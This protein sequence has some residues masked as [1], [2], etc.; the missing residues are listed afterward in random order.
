MGNSS[1][2]SP[3]LWKLC[4]SRLEPRVRVFWLSR[5][6]KKRKDSRAVRDKKY[7]CARNAVKRARTRQRDRCKLGSPAPVHFS[8]LFLFSFFG[9]FSFFFP[10]S[11]VAKLPAL[12]HLKFS[13][14]SCVDPRRCCVKKKRKIQKERTRLSLWP[15]RRHS[16]TPP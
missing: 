11:P 3:T 1:H 6:K 10:Q 8:S 7:F 16:A 9:C 12:L 5:T 14:L 2:N 4:E 15:T 13:N